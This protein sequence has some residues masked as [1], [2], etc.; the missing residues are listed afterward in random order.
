M[1][2][3]TKEVADYLRENIDFYKFSKL[4]KK[5]GSQ[6]NSPQGRFLK[7]TI[8]ELAIEEFSNNTMA[9][10]NQNGC[11]FL[12]TGLTDTRLEM[13]YTEGAIFTKK[14][15]LRE[16]C[17][18][19]LTN[20]HGTNIHT[21]LPTY[22]ADFLIFISECGAIL[23]DKQPTLI[24]HSIVGGDG[25]IAKVPSVDGIIVADYNIMNGGNQQEVILDMSSIYKEFINNLDP[26]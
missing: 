22:Y 17:T 10:V 26:A 14:R 18:F 4:V 20:S 6:F 5:M 16:N 12:I 3:T 21:G 11:D 19:K 2:Y 7:S 25:I 23:F 24:Q 9:Y 13:K 8:L 1:T 15:T